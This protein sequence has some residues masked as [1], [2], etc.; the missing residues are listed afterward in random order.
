M[1]GINLFAAKTQGTTSITSA[2]TTANVLLTKPAACNVIRVKNID[3]D[4]VA[5]INFGGSTVEATVP[6][7]ATPGSI[8]IGAG[9]TAGFSVP[10]GTTHAAAIC[11]A[12]TPIVYFTP[13]NG[14]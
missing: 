7:G 11:T 2:V 4:N 6:A 9:E 1:S 14:V 10:E 8:P 5:Y 12:G 13:G 3:A